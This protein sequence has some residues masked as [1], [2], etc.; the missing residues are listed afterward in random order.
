[1]VQ[2]EEEMVMFS[3]DASSLFPVAAVGGWRYDGIVVLSSGEE[4][5]DGGR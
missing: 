1:M 3:V 4:D 5:D 2:E